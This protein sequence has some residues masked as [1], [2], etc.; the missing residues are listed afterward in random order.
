MSKYKS[1]KIVIDGYT[2]DSKVEAKYYEQLKEAKAKGMIQ[3]FELQPQYELIKKFTDAEGKK[4]RAIKY[5][6]DFAVYQFDGS[7]WVIDI[8]GMA[9]ETAKLKRKMFL[10]KYGYSYKLKWL[11]WYKGEWK[12]Y[13][14]VQKI[15]RG[16]KRE[17]AAEKTTTKAN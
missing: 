12:E 7:V 6:A 14:E 1:Q 4:H 15:R 17:Q 2:F 9:T 8:K 10:S 16:N 13:D 11:V 3:S 5:K